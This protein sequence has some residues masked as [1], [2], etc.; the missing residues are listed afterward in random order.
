MLILL[1]LTN[2]MEETRLKIITLFLFINSF[3]FGFGAMVSAIGGNS[4]HFHKD[5]VI[6]IISIGLC[7]IMGYLKNIW[8]TLK[9]K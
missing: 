2:N 8:D 1:L 4:D 9:S 5:C 6:A 3:L 7:G